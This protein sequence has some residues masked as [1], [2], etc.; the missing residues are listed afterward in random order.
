[1]KSCFL[2]SGAGSA[3]DPMERDQL[4]GNGQRIECG[5]W[6]KFL[7]AHHTALFG[8][9]A[10]LR[11]LITAIIKAA[12][13]G[14]ASILE[15]GCG[16]GAAAFM[17]ADLGYQVLAVDGDE[18]VI[19]WIR[20]RHP[21]FFEYVSFLRADA[22][23]LPLRDRSV[24]LAFSQ[25]VLEHY[26]DDM[27]IRL[28]QEQRR[29]AEVVVFDVPNSRHGADRLRGDERLL[30]ISVY[31]RLCRKAGLSVK[32]IYGRRWV[33]GERWL[34]EEALCAV[35]ALA[36]WFSQSSIFVCIPIREE[37]ES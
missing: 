4:R 17:L 5:S 33:F 30:P 31:R 24:T 28:L 22:R 27:I 21:F 32:A 18:E 9:A 34:P 2:R 25:G 26:Q 36:R 8:Q 11:N 12:P 20:A 10:R 37:V 19:R 3:P 29:V 15:V 23:L 1:M 16:S 6:A 13:V 35:P 7:G 14:S